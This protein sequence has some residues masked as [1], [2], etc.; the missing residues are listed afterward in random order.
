MNRY[1]F[2][3][4]LD[5]YKGLS[6]STGYMPSGTNAYIAKLDNFYGKGKH[7]YFYSKEEWDAYNKNKGYAKNAEKNKKGNESKWEKMIK[8][9]NVRDSE[10]NLNVYDNY[11]RYLDFNQYLSDTRSTPILNAISYGYN[12]KEMEET[13]KA[14]SKAIEFNKREEESF[15]EKLKNDKT[16][17]DYDKKH[18]LENFE[19][20]KEMLNKYYEIT[21]DEESFDK[22]RDKTLKENFENR[23]YN[24]NY[25]FDNY[26][27]PETLNEKIGE[28]GNEILLGNYT[29]FMDFAKEFFE[30]KGYDDKY[31]K[32]WLSQLPKILDKKRYI[33]LK[34]IKRDELIPS[35]LEKEWGWI[36]KNN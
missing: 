30:R 7:R 5:K 28:L 36:F 8:P 27:V 34:R 10:T 14:I 25:P 32:I 4:N 22:H 3:S 13:K 35:D 15:K 11:M 18:I 17:S 2:Y 23:L 26:P 29:N 1:E 12:T 6:H 20:Q 21:K 16:L 31:A 9:N 24:K 33:Y 19:L